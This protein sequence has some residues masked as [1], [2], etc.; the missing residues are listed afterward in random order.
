LAPRDIASRAAKEVC[1]EGRGVGPGG[2]G[3]YLDFA[4][5]ISRLGENKIRERYGNLF[6]M[7][8][9]IT[10]ENAYK[11]PMRIYPAVHYTMGGAWVDY[12]LMSNLPGLFVVGEANFSDHG[13]NRLGAS[14]LMQGLAD[15][16]FVL[17]YTIGNYIAT[18]KQAKP[19]TSH[20][21]FKKAE[22]NI[23]AFTN[24]LLS[25]KGRRSAT[26]LHRE[27]GH[28]LWEK[29][30][31]ARDEAGLKEALKRI[32]ELREEFW[33]NV[34]VTG[35]SGE[36]NQNLEY[37]GRVADFMEFAEL[38]CLDALHRNES[39]GGHFRTEYQTPDGEA[40]RDDENFA[41]VAAWEY[42]G[43]G[44]QPELHKE[45]LAYEEVHMST[46]SYK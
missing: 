12:N 42:K 11:V 3:V 34:N 21:E 39:C 16:Y 5:A 30:G 8:E 24:K 2:L 35:D 20:P 9:K 32:P 27:L 7:Y 29:C 26:S 13:A 19:S 17:P 14:A 6:D 33:K 46:R 44:K 1:D 23:R 10:G 18:A 37:A 40:K 31:M 41:Y 28:L 25:I 45:S 43:A 38:L 15:G 36:L 4:D 22:E